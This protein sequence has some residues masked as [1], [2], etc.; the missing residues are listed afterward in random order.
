MD[1]LIEAAIKGNKEAYIDLI[2]II[3]GDLYRI[4]HARLN[5]IEDVNDAIE[6]TILKSYKNL[7]KLKNNGYF[8]TWITKILINECNNIYRINK[9]NNEIADRIMV[10]QGNKIKE[11]DIRD[12]KKVEDKL[13]FERMISNLSY[14]ERLI[15]ILYYNN[16]HTVADIANILDMNVNTVKSK[17]LRAKEKIKLKMKGGD[18]NGTA[19]RIG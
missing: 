12:I 4:A 19:G 15:V 6:E 9:K 10:L 1:E 13:D 14:D 2:N 18:Y 3:R 8:K 11:N 7:K 5:D 17:L 16:R